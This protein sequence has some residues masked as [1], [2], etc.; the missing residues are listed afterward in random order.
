MQKEVA[1]GDLLTFFYCKLMTLG[2]GLSRGLFVAVQLIHQLIPKSFCTIS[3]VTELLFGLFGQFA[4]FG[5]IP[6][7]LSLVFHFIPDF[8][9]FITQFIQFILGRIPGLASRI[10]RLVSTSLQA[11][12]C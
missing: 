7:F 6:K 9:G 2:F 5:L 8:L 4:G 11:I 10:G 12:S 1:F 3:K